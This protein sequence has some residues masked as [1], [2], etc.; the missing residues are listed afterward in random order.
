MTPSSPRAGVVTFIGSGELAPSMSRVHRAILARVPSPVRAVFV[1][2]PA[3]FEPN[4]DDIGRK[5]VAYLRDRL[6]VSCAVCAYH[7]PGD[8]APSTL[9]EALRQLE[10]A[11]YIFAGPGSPTYAVR[12]WRASPVFDVMARRLGEG[13]SLV[14]ASAAAIAVGAF[15][16]PV[17]EIFKAG[18]DPHWV[19]GLDLLGPFGLR[20]AIVPHWNNAEGAGYDTRYCFMG[21]ERFRALRDALDPGVT[22]LGIDEYTACSIDLAK[23][24]CA[25]LGAG[26][27]TVL[28]GA[29][30][31]SFA[32]GETFSLDLLRSAPLGRR[33]PAGDESE[34]A[35]RA[36]VER[37]LRSA[38]DRAGRLVSGSGPVDPLEAAGVVAGLV[39]AL[40]DARAIAIQTLD[41]DAALRAVLRRWLDALE[42]DRASDVRPYVELLVDVRS[43]LRARGIYDLADLIRDG[44]AAL[45]VTLEDAAAETVWR[46][47]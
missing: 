5:A 23:G 12:M 25:V 37:A 4:V 41:A 20:L 11:N 45:G 39:A 28:S 33:A 43:R 36:P 15:A 16:L 14:F 31:S 3:G 42:P 44:L 13:A 46:R 21:E 47:T 32:A 2:T 6:G 22:V 27:V 38:V 17:Y 7:R 29:G 19:E 8:P 35:E 24:E 18:A 40:A 10:R 30:E 34:R 9:R 26:A 1:D